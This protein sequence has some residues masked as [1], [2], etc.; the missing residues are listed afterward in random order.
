[1]TTPALKTSLFALI[2]L[3]V[4]A[5]PSVAEDQVILKSGS[6][7]TG[8]ILEVSPKGVVIDIPGLGKV[9]VPRSQ[10]DRVIGGPNADPPPD[11]PVPAEPVPPVEPP[12]L[13]PTE[14]DAVEIPYEDLE[15]GRRVLVLVMGKEHEGWAESGLRVLGEVEVV[16]PKRLKIVFDPGAGLLGYQW[17][18]RDRI[19]RVIRVM[20]YPERRILFFDS[21]AGGSWV[22][23]RNSEGIM[24]RGRLEGVNEGGLVTV[25]CPGEGGLKQVSFGLETLRTMRA[26]TRGDEIAEKVKSLVPGEPVSLSI[27]G[28]RG[29]VAGRLTGVT[30]D[31]LS[32]EIVDGAETA[33][34]TVE[35]FTGCAILALRTLPDELREGFR[36]ISRDDHVTV[37]TC[38]E[39]DEERVRVSITGKFLAADLESIT[40]LGRDGLTTVAVG[41]VRA[42]SRPDPGKVAVL[43][44]GMEES[45]SESTLPIL[46]GMAR[47]EA[48]KRL[49]G[50]PEGIDVVYEDGRVT[51]IYC[52]PPYTGPV[53]GVR[54]GAD[55]ATAL[56]KTDLVFEKQID[57][58]KE[59]PAVVS[60][61]LSYTLKGYVVALLVTKRGMV[62]AMELTAR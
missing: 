31:F 39:N 15:A 20:G 52:R 2:A 48:E 21:V 51:K 50:N 19:A 6:V 40:L 11:E 27:R 60:T 43:I 29:E 3:A 49:P 46:P 32:L 41:S 36:D 18:S 55:L 4:L 33:P 16:G 10:I 28:T 34:R 59:G 45:N 47:E 13:P 5:A 37:R 58:K 24:F 12:P 35:I 57:P 61:M 53:F 30:D 44:E 14:E 9:D 42:I 17:L 56:E 62:L 54:I 26:I 25:T 22:E 7:L 1:M 8:K 23:G 38:V